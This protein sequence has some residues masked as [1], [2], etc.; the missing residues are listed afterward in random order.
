[1]DSDRTRGTGTARLLAS[2]AVLLGLFLMH[3]SP[4]TASGG[5]HGSARATLTAH[6][7]HTPTAVVPSGPDAARVQVVD[8]TAAHGAQCVAIPVERHLPL[9]AAPFVAVVAL[10]V[11]AGWALRR[12]WS[13][14]GTGRRGPPG[15][16]GLMLQVCV[17]RM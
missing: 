7:E 14:G 15:G 9:P 4:V 5:C 12:A 11:L 2:C 1:M 6:G 17:A 13:P 16:R 10:A 3:G 8:G